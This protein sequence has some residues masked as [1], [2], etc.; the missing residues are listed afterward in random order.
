LDLTA[1]SLGS[2]RFFHSILSPGAPFDTFYKMWP[3]FRV[4]LT[5]YVLALAP[6][7]DLG[8]AASVSCVQA[9]RSAK[10]YAHPTNRESSG[11][12]VTKTITT[13]QLSTRTYVFAGGRYWATAHHL[14]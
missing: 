13:T 14:L 2:A 4:Q 1:T 8:L 7:F 5:L 3:S 6:F 11:T 12:P 10:S 9:V